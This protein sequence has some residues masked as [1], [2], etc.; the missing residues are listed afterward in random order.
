MLKQDKIFETNLFSQGDCVSYETIDNLD[1][2]G[3]QSCTIPYKIR[4][5]PECGNKFSNYLRVKYDCVPDFYPANSMCSFNSFT[6][7]KG[8]IS[9][10]NYPVFAQNI[11]CETNINVNTL[12]LIKV[13]IKDL[14]LDSK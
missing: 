11:N 7:T 5:L 13:Y 14:S 9:S 10:P 6:Q 2:A 1:C 3:R 12:S 4:Q 8:V